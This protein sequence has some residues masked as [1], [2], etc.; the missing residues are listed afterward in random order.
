MRSYALRRVALMVPTLLGLSLFAFALAHLAPGDPAREFLRRTT[1]QPPTEAEVAAIRRELGLDRPVVV[2]YG[3][4]LGH[5]IRGDL[6]ISY[7][8]RRPVADELGRRVPATLELALPAAAMALLIAI[9]LGTISAVQRNRAVDQLVRVVALAGASIPSFWLALL[10]I[11]FFSVKLSLFPVAGRHGLSSV[12]L[13]AFAL[14]LTPAAVLARFSRSAV[15]EALGEDYVRTARAKGLPERLVVARHAL[16]NALV[17]VIT[18]FG[19]NVGHL[20][21]GTVVIEAIFA[22][23]GL[24][25]LTLDAILQRDYPT[26]Q[27]VV[28]F[29]GAAFVVI[30]LVVDFAYGALD[31]RIRLGASAGRWR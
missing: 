6:G 12:V 7:A 8:T 30:N 28:L 20:V 1:D 27:G 9:P 24:G 26:L 22:W 18:A 3:S 14:A 16:R 31:P 19:T 13:P 21:A 17:P 11:V 29:T 4:W 25:K 2:Q 5:A 15:L 10:L 23:P